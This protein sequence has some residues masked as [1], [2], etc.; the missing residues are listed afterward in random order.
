MSQL[1]KHIDAIFKD[2]EKQHTDQLKFLKDIQSDAGK[3]KKELR[4]LLEKREKSSNALTKLGEIQNQFAAQFDSRERRGL[5][6]KEN[7][8]ELWNVNNAFKGLDKYL[9]QIHGHLTKVKSISHRGNI[10]SVAPHYTLIE[11]WFDEISGRTGDL[12]SQWK[13]DATGNGNVI[14]KLLDDL[15]EPVKRCFQDIEKSINLLKERK[16]RHSHKK[17]SYQEISKYVTKLRNR[18][19]KLDSLLLDSLL[20]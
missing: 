10:Y 2:N 1:N 15:R 12:R 19:K 13:R 3:T 9:S 7:I 6:L 17:E 20:Q 4:S 11:G 16:Y 5:E 14:G 18:I 8:E